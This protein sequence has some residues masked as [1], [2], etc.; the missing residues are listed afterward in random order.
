MLI[1]EWES[2]EALEIILL[3]EEP[4]P[5]QPHLFTMFMRRMVTWTT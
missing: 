3:E 4:E 5:L 2:L 1:L